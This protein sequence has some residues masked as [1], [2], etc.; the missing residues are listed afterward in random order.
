MS[1]LINIQISR[2]ITAVE[3]RERDWDCRDTFCRDSIGNVADLTGQVYARLEP[4]NS[5]TGVFAH[6]NQA[7]V[8]PSHGG[9]N[10]S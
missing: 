5:L 1:I 2:L 6:F 7:R 3:S 8:N 10:C 4:L 9:V